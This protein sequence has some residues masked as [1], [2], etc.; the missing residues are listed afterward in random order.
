MFN[1]VSFR[2]HLRPSIGAPP[3][4]GEWASPVPRPTGASTGASRYI[5]SLHLSPPSQRVMHLTIWVRCELAMKNHPTSMKEPMKV[6]RVSMKALLGTV[7][8]SP[9]RHLTNTRP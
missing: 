7:I 9:G 6:P 3:P 4:G 8:Q 2:L 5:Q 1:L